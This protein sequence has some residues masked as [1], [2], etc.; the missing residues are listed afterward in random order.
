MA[1]IPAVFLQ[2]FAWLTLLVVVE[3]GM[4]HSGWVRDLLRL[5]QVYVTVEL[6][7]HKPMEAGVA[8]LL[9]RS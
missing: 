7:F 4:K 3:R 1:V 6:L 2:D 9:L 5:M 8:W